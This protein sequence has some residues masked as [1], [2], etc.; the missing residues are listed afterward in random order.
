MLESQNALA[1]AGAAF[2]SSVTW[3][4]G[5]SMY[6]RLS[7]LYPA[8]TVNFTRAWMALPIVLGFSIFSSFLSGDSLFS[9]FQKVQ[10]NNISWLFVSLIASYALGDILFL[11]STRILGIPTALAVAST[12]PLIAA[13]FGWVFLGEALGLLAVLG[14]ATTIVGV[15]LVV[16][17]GKKT[18]I[19][20]AAEEPQRFGLGLLLAFGT[21]VFW[22]VNS[23]ASGQG[24]KGIGAM[25]ANA[26]R[27]AMALF[28]VPLIGRLV[29]RRLVL[30]IDRKILVKSTPVFILESVGGSFFYL[31]GMSH[32]PLAVA[33]TLTSLAPVLTLPVAV[34]FGW[35]R[36]SKTKT[37]G[38]VLVVM[39]VWGLVQR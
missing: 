13:M 28:L 22:S 3:A 27:M 14:V 12:F 23:F 11:A 29:E 8:H 20:K 10:T 19:E 2:L 37:L 21:A 9:E 30:K 18:R 15:M 35:E 33:A 26:I 1:G 17:A 32:A 6:S 5:S 34:W 36:F 4:I 16:L 24:A 7:L 25:E 31:Y 38:I 39:G